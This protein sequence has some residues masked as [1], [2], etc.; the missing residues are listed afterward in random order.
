MPTREQMQ[1][2]LRAEDQMR[3]VDLEEMDGGRHHAYDV[4]NHLIAEPNEAR[5]LLVAAR[6]ALTNG[7]PWQTQHA[8][9]KLIDDY[10]KRTT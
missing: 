10:L 5:T 7:R 2:R 9:W 8:A 4:V 1:N 6:T 3:H